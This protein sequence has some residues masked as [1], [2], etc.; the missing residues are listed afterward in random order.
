MGVP[1]Y[2]TD[3]GWGSALLC[4]LADLVHDLFRRGFEPGRGRARVWY[5]TCRNTF[6]VGVEATHLCGLRVVWLVVGILDVKERR[7][8]LRLARGMVRARNKRGLASKRTFDLRFCSL[9][10]LSQ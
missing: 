4:E 1:Q 2:D 10:H 5:S 9:L 7:V 6:A 3:L 8:G